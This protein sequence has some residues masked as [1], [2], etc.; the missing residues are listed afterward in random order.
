MFRHLKEVR[1]AFGNRHLRDVHLKAVDAVDCLNSCEADLIRCIQ[2]MDA[3]LVYRHLGYG[4]V[5]RYCVEALRLSEHQ[6]YAYTA[7]A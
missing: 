3:K 6:S 1:A 2:E 4:S 5:F 7:V